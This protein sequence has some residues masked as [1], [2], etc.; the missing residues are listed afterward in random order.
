MNDQPINVIGI[1]WK[2]IGVEMAI[3]VTVMLF[4]I[5]RGA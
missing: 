5:W 1:C 2:V 4:E 3:I